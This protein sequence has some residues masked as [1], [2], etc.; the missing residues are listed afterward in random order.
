MGKLTPFNMIFE[1]Q[2][3]A[4]A[5]SYSQVRDPHVYVDPDHKWISI[6]RETLHL[7]KL[8]E[9]MQH[10]V[11]LVKDIYVRLSGVGAW[12]DPPRGLHVVD[13][14]TNVRRGYSFLDEEPFQS[15]KHAF[16]LSLVEREKLGAFV[17]DGNW[18]WNHVAIKD[19]LQRADA[20]WGHL[21]HALYVGVHLSSRVTQFLQHQLRNSDR[22]RN[23]LFQG[24][25][26]FFLSRYSKTTNLKGKD[27]CTP[28]VL[29]APLRELLLVILGDGFR[30]AQAILAGIVHGEE[31]RWLYRT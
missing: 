11:R 29:S 22:P 5:L 8:R 6:G 12:P 2:Q 4:S 3:F 26:G 14:F 10:L 31:A 7:R 16:F 1:L 18:H 30:E 20:L 28:A 24:E 23:L 15:K 9:G 13:D 19:F 25:E 27:A 17:A 21:V